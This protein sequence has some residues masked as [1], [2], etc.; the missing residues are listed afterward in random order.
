MAR[1]YYSRRFSYN[2]PYP[3]DLDA[4]SVQELVDG[5]KDSIDLEK[6]K[7]IKSYVSKLKLAINNQFPLWTQT[8]A[9]FGAHVYAKNVGKKKTYLV[10]IKL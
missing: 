4:G 1:G 8:A 3:K 9:S 10:H 6:L 7:D 5:I 2:I